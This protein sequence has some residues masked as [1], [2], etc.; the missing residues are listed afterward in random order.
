MIALESGSV[1][2]EAFVVEVNLPA[3]AQLGVSPIGQPPHAVTVADILKCIETGQARVVDGGKIAAQAKSRTS[4]RAKRTTYIR[5]ES[6]ASEVS[7]SPYESGGQ[8]SAAV[9]PLSETSVS[10]GFAFTSSRF[11]QKDR[12]SDVPPNTE[13]WEWSRA[14]TRMFG[15]FRPS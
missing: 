11:V 12:A 3:L 5:R 7:Y 9:E 4:A 2:V 8:F 6:G 1:L 15:R 10:V 13:S 14:K